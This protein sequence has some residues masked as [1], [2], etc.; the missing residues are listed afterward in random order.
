M[1]R[2]TPARRAR[3]TAAQFGELQQREPGERDDRDRQRRASGRGTASASTAAVSIS[4]AARR[5]RCRGRTT[6][7]SPRRRSAASRRRRRPAP[8]R[9]TA[10]ELH[11]VDAE[12]EAPHG[13]RTARAAAP[14]AR[15][16]ASARANAR[17]RLRQRPPRARRCT[18][19][20]TS[21]IARDQRPMLRPRLEALERRRPRRLAAERLADRRGELRRQRGLDADERDRG[22]AVLEPDLEPV[23]RVRV[24][25]DAVAPLDVADRR[26]AVGV[27]AAPGHESGRPHRG[28]R[29]GAAEVEAAVA[30]ELRPQRAQR[31]RDRARRRRR[32]SARSSTPC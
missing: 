20:A 15:F 23:R 10:Q 14:A 9:R 11:E 2:P 30:L 32:R 17:I 7:R 5:P 19:A 29:V 18:R 31:R 4:S 12:R 27:G 26:D 21:A 22:V 6:R 3:A 24:D 1:A 13:Q 28:P 16:A 25:D 8:T